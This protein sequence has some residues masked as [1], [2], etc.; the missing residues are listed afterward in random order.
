MLL[1]QI[2]FEVTF[3]HCEKPLYA[4]TMTSQIKRNESNQVEAAV[5]DSTTP[6][7]NKAKLEVQIIVIVVFALSFRRKSDFSAFIKRFLTP[8][9][10]SF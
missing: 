9:N 10:P 2:I 1:D 4:A 5:D 8:F 7:Q 3:N 6:T